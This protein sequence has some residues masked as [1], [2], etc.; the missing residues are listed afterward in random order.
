VPEKHILID[1]GV[2]GQALIRYPYAPFER[3][4]MAFLKY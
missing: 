3:G 4:L 1:Y 2:F